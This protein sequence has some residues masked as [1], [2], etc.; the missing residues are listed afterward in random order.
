MQRTLNHVP[1]TGQRNS[2]LSTSSSFYLLRRFANCFLGLWWAYIQMLS[3]IPLYMCKASL[4]EECVLAKTST[5]PRI[6]IT[7][8]HHS[9]RSRHRSGYSTEISILVRKILRCVRLVSTSRTQFCICLL[10]CF[11]QNFEKSNEGKLLL[12]KEQWCPAPLLHDLD[13]TRPF[14]IQCNANQFAVGAIKCENG[15][16][17]PTAFM[18][19]KFNSDQRSSCLG[20]GFWSCCRS[21]FS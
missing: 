12:L 17:V 1:T 21:H 7:S 8:W 5:T 4:T 14:S 18:S 13:F 6:L 11:W 10:Y 20:A 2:T 16:E 19:H 3:E 15:Q 9:N